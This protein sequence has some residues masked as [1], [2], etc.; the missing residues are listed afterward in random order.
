M[1]RDDLADSEF[2]AD[3]RHARF[4]LSLDRVELLEELRPMGLRIEQ[5]D[6]RPYAALLGRLVVVDCGDAPAKERKPFVGHGS[7]SWPATRVAST[8]Q[9]LGGRHVQRSLCDRPTPW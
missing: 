5:R 1:H 4:N 8:P 2:V 6:L 7:T 9:A 3:R